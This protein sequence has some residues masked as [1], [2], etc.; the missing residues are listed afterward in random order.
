[1]ARKA[2]RI[3]HCHGLT[4]FSVDADLFIGCQTKVS[5]QGINGKVK[6]GSI[7]ERAQYFKQP[8]ISDEIAHFRKRNRSDKEN[9]HNEAGIEKLGEN[10]AEVVPK[11]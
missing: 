3:N 10:S 9:E 8:A 4:F 1:M 6:Q 5:T 2:R 7:Y 11:P